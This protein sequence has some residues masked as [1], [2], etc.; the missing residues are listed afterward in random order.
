MY[1]CMCIYIYIHKYVCMY[2][3]LKGRL[4]KQYVIGR[5]NS[6]DVATIMDFRRSKREMIS[7]A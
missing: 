5:R 2:V 4:L 7:R 3:S 6:Y 1:A